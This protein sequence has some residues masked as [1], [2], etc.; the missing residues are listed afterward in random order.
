MHWTALMERRKA[1]RSIMSKLRLFSKELE[2]PTRLP[3]EEMMPQS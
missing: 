3:P 2:A 1:N